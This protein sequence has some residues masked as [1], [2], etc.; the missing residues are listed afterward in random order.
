MKLSKDTLE[1]LQNFSTINSKIVFQT[2]NTLKTVSETRNVF[3]QAEITDEIT[4]EFAI[5]DL[6]EFLS[7]LS[8]TGEDSEI[9]LDTFLTIKNGR[10]KAKYFPYDP[11]MVNIPKTVTMPEI[12]VSITLSEGDLAAIRKGCAI[13]GVGSIAITG[14]DGEISLRVYDPKNP[15]S[16]EYA[17]VIDESNEATDSFN[18]VLDI[19]NLKMIP[20]DYQVDISK[21]LI[22]QLSSKTLPLNYWVAIEKTST[23]GE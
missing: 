12:D 13:I 23:F 4:D 7:V 16:H 15:S 18:F 11:S 1:I 8:L 9:S 19:S 10:S 22:M 2:G 3:A 6:K 17:I 14:N 5:S 20:G 21:K